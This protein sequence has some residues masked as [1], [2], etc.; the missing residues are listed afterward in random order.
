[1]FLMDPIVRAYKE[2]RTFALGVRFV[3][4]AC[5]FCLLSPVISHFGMFGAVI[6][7]V[8]A[9]VLERIAM[10]WKTAR[11]VD[12]TA[13]DL[14]LYYDFFKI[15]GVTATGGLCAY[16]A[17]SLLKPYL[18]LPRILVVG[19]CFTGVYL[20]LFYFLRLPGWDALS[21]ERLKVF[22]QTRLA[23]LKNAGA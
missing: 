19:I 13:K 1:V 20:P 6:L 10:G 3:I 9:Q 7:A 14:K 2:L 4:F 23:R 12:A 15:A 11:T 16:A 8:G 21:H 5:L 17:R 22:V 18:L